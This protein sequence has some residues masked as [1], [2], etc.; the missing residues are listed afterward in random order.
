MVYSWRHQ[1]CDV[2]SLHTT[3]A[4]TC[5]IDL[6]EYIFFGYIEWRETASEFGIEMAVCWEREPVGRED[7]SLVKWQNSKGVNED[8]KLE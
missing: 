8:L 6:I 1:S 5:N 3:A 4:N 2:H 7:K